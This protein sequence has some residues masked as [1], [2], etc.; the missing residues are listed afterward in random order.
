MIRLLHCADVHL[1]ADEKS[2]G[3]AVLQE[4][5]DTAN[6]EKAHFLLICGDL[7]DSFSDADALRRDVAEISNTCRCEILYIPGNHE[8]HGKTGVLSNFDFGKLKPLI[9]MPYDKI[10]RNLQDDTVEFVTIP[11][12]SN[13]STW[14]DWNISA[15]EAKA[16]VA[17]VHATVGNMAYTGPDDCDVEEDG[18]ILGSEFFT[19]NKVLYAA[20]GHIHGYRRQTVENTLLSYPGSATVWRKGESGPRKTVLVDIDKGNMMP[21]RDIVIAAAGQY[22]CCEMPLSLDGSMPDV[23]SALK[24]Y[25]PND[26]LELVLTG[27]IENEALLRDIAA[28]LQ[29]CG[30]TFFRKAILNKEKTGVFPGLAKQP[31]AAGFLKIWQQ[32]APEDGTIKPE[33][34]ARARQLALESIKA[35]MEA[36]Q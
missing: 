9:K 34:W 23:A 20:L 5:V 15:S 35:R 8:E 14:R 30:R 16:R 36:R 22:R 21:P 17:L 31:L 10:F 2:Y 26:L 18:G 4:I 32:G 7:F 13:Y 25:G 33:V 19:R 3:L 6:R 29:D 27:V 1:K 24:Q 28:V 12:Q 11:H